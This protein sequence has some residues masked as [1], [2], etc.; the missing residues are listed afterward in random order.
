MR[1]AF[2]LGHQSTPRKVQQVPKFPRLDEKENV[3]QGFIEQGQHEALCKHSAGELWLRTLLAL[4]YTYGIRKGELLNLRCS[5]VDLADR[6]IRLHKTKNG[7]P[8]H[9]VLTSE[10]FTLVQACMMGK[11]ADD[12]LFTYK[13][14][15]HV[16]DFRK[17][18]A[19]IT[20]A[21]GVLDLLFHDLRRSGVRGMVR[22][23]ISQ[24]VAMKISGHETES[25]FRRYDIGDD[26]D[27]IEAAR[28]IELRQK[29]QKQAMIEKPTQNLHNSPS[30]PS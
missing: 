16:R 11:A 8:R 18:W 2:N 17:P 21:A 6:V 4:G 5:Q 7:K 10:C 3:R 12:Y 30:L 27:L 23:G 25:T 24:H 13:N 1:R 15:D 26:K 14:G 22:S 28:L 19:R 20:K 9:A 29:E